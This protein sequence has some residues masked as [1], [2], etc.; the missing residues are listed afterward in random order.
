MGIQKSPGAKNSRVIHKPYINPTDAVSH[1]QTLNRQGME[2]YFTPVVFSDIN[3]GRLAENALSVKSL[4]FD[5]DVG[6]K[7]NSYPTQPDAIN[8]LQNFIG[9][10]GLKPTIVVSTG[11][12]YAAYWTFT[13][14]LDIPV[15][16]TMAQILVGLARQNNFIIDKCTEDAA[17]VMRMP[18]TIH[19]KSGGN[20][21]SVIIDT[22]KDWE[23]NE[24]LEQ[25][26]KTYSGITAPLLARTST[27]TTHSVAPKVS[28]VTPPLSSP[29]MAQVLAQTGVRPQKPKVKAEPI[30]RN[31]GCMLTAGLC[32]EP[33]W[34]AAMSVLKRCVDGREWAHK[35]SAMDKGRYVYDDTERKFT[36][37][38]DD[39]PARCDRFYSL[40]PDICLKCPHRGKITSPIQLH[41]LPAEG[42]VEVA[43]TPIPEQSPG[44]SLAPVQPVTARPAHLEIPKDFDFPMMALRDAE[45]GVD[46]RGIL[47][48]F[49]KKDDYGKWI[50]V[51]QLICSVQLYYTHTVHSVDDDGAPKR[52]HWFVAIHPD[53]RK[54]KLPLNIHADM[55]SQA[56]M[57]WFYQGNMF[58]ASSGIK[59]G[60]LVAFMQAY[61]KSVIS[62]NVELKTVDKFGWCKNFH[63]PKLD[64]EV[65]GFVVGKGIVTET[66]IYPVHHSDV[67]ERIAEDE[68]G[69]SGNLEN[70][71]HVPRMYKTLDQKIAQL[72]ICLAFAAPFM[73]YC[74]G[75]AKSATMSLWS[76]QSGLGK[77]QLLRAC[78]SIWGHPD[79]QFV[80]RNSSQVLR[81]RKLSTLHNLPCFMDEL[82][83]VKDEDLYSL[84]YTLVDGREKQK[85]HSSGADMVKT[86]SWNTVTFTTGNK[87]FKEAASKYCG[88]SDASLLRVIEFECNF[89]TYEDMPKVKEYINAC[90]AMCSD[91]YGVAGPE[92]MY[93]LF[94][95][96]DRLETLRYRI[97]TWCVNHNY[98]NEERFFSNPCAIALIVGRWACEFGILDFDM[99]AL[100]AWV[101]GDFSDYNRAIHK[102]M[103][104]FHKEVIG[105]YLMER[106]LNT[107]IV[108]S[109]Y[110][111]AHCHETSSTDFSMDRYI[112]S[113]PKKEVYVRQERAEKAIYISVTDIK[114][115]CK[116][117]SY[118][119]TILKKTLELQRINVETV[120]YNLGQGI[121]WA[122]MPTIKCLKLT[123]KGPRK[124][125]GRKTNPEHY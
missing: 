118:S 97:E 94:Q 111:E 125:P 44:L 55:N 28:H 81:M 68:M 70:W 9:A 25:A 106:Q 34:Y 73:R 51:E 98:T 22:G 67:C 10:T 27:P 3:K 41:N 50:Q 124:K 59:P 45:F 56:I 64:C 109:A 36:H 29:A 89:K 105:Q 104:P 48:R 62:S 85:L 92:F 77:S 5:I 112:I 103:K 96:R 8:A 99:D 12:G 117:K 110:R 52:V 4:W 37:A 53:G 21:A 15:W 72:A 1:A 40:N 43:A 32:S 91:N 26:K 49:S 101:L 113:Y 18:G 13:A 90:I 79:R 35:L 120:V 23:P 7:F 20:L 63:D 6:K 60:L 71:K 122:A 93:Q 80:Q 83:D 116:S 2:T 114:N 78:A 46:K 86:G 47:Y 121:S 108:A 82:T 102:E 57:R 61:L 87:S 69:V 58:P 42:S 75:A 84:A 88:D 95:K 11:T 30:V 38:P 19:H 54:E 107:L 100:E 119:Y 66:G 39:M 123:P 14:S 17:R 115:W 24:W 31:C 76:S 16:K 74:S 65:E 33:Q